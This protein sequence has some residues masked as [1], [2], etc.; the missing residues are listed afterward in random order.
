MSQEA[1]GHDLMGYVQSS[2]GGDR[3]VGTAHGF[4]SWEEKYSC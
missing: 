3:V 1:R 2:S 4:D